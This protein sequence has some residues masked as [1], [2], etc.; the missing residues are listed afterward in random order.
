MK[1]ETNTIDV[2]KLSLIIIVATITA[3]ILSP[4]SLV[5]WAQNL[6]ISPWSDALVEWTQQWHDW[7]EEIGITWFFETMRQFFQFLRKM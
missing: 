6:P 7:L 2:R 3:A 1:N 4:Q 5:T